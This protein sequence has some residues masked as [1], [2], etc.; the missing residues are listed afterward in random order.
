MTRRILVL[1]LLLSALPA[2]GVRGPLYL[3]ATEAAE[4]HVG[5]VPDGNGADESAEGESA[6]EHE[7]AESDGTAR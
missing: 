7:A 3:P 1:V 6:E 4:T 5:P 2:C